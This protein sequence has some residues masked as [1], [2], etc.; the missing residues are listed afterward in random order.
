M[1][2]LNFMDLEP[3]ELASLGFKDVPVAGYRT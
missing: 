2:K 3:G 1:G